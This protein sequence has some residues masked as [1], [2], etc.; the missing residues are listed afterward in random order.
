MPL[1]EMAAAQQSL[2]Q[3]SVVEAAVQSTQIYENIATE[4][5]TN[6]ALIEAVEQSVT[7][8]DSIEELQK[9]ALV[10]Q[11]HRRPAFDRE[12]Y[13]SEIQPTDRI[14]KQTV[15]PYEPIREEVYATQQLI[16]AYIIASAT[17]RGELSDDLSETEKKHIRLGIAIVVGFAAG[18]PAG[19]VLG[20][21]AAVGTA[22][23]TGAWASRELDGYY[24]IKQRQQLPGSEPDSHQ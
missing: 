9:M 18:L 17:D 10:S 2:I 20:P 12:V 8:A 24:D 4:L 13:E 15:D 23:G 6:Q 3:P 14:Y 5:A 7:I 1:Q 19:F 16:A 11:C 22:L 21:A